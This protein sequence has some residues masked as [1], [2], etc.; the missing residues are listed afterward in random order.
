M[1]RL[2]KSSAWFINRAF[3]SPLPEQ[4]D[5]GLTLERQ[6][7][8]L[9]T[10]ANLPLRPVSMVQHLTNI[11]ST[12]VEWV[13]G[14]CWTNVERS[15]QTASTPFNIFENKGNFVWKLNESLI[16]FKFDSTRFQHFLRFQQC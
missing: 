15:V 16:R 13:L 2:Q 9:F 14:K 6:H 4:I 8:N 3:T 7:S 1:N 11:R 10:V 12:K 5:E